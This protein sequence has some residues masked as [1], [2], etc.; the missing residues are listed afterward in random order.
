MGYAEF[1]LVR[2]SA[3]ND[4][5]AYANDYRVAKDP[6]SVGVE[7]NLF[8]YRPMPVAVRLDGGQ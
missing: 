2:R 6:A 3:L 8:R 7:R 1:D 4:A 5:I